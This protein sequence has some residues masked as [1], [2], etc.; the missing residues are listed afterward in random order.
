MASAAEG[1]LNFNYLELKLN[2]HPWLVA[3]VFDSTGIES[4]KFER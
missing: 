4:V 1:L 2:G 3:T